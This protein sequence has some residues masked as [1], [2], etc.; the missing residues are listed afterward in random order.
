MVLCY[1]AEFRGSEVFKDVQALAQ[2]NEPRDETLGLVARRDMPASSKDRQQGLGLVKIILPVPVRGSSCT[3]T[4][5]GP[6]DSGVKPV[7]SV[8]KG[9]VP[10]VAGTMSGWLACNLTTDAVEMG[11]AIC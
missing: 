9:P 4:F 8:A 1:L 6:S 10:G 3:C 5:S 11:Q 7:N 2:I